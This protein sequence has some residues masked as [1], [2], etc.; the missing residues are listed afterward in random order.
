MEM[1]IVVTIIAAVVTISMPYIR[2]RNYETRRVLR[3]MIVMSRELHT[4]AK[5]QGAVF[6]LVIDMG[7]DKDGKRTKQ[8][9]W[10]ERANAGTIMKPNEEALALERA[11]E[12]D[13]AKRKDPNGFEEDH[14]VIHKH[15]ELPSG[16]SFER[17]E[18]TRV[19]DPITHGKAYIHY[20]PQ[21]LVDE[22]AIQIKGEKDQA[23]TIAISPLTGKAELI[24]KKVTLQDMRSQ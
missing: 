9:F 3:Q 1:M 14:Q 5:L 10:V 8:S 24:Q 16:M 4:R 18:L 20:M 7:D 17:V 19:K 12:T 15:T 23:W 6:R 11:K 2:S 22:A 21:G 13:E